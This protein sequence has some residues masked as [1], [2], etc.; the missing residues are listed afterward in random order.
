[1]NGELGFE[2]LWSGSRTGNLTFLPSNA[3]CGVK[4]SDICVFQNATETVMT[5]RL[6]FG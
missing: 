5:E 1:M 2:V 3:R 6:E 4:I